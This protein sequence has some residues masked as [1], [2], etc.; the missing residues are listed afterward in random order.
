[1]Y[2]IFS[3]SRTDVYDYLRC[4]KIVAL[5][6][7]KNLKKPKPEKK[8]IP[9]RNFRY[10]IGTIGEVLT[11]KAFSTEDII[12][13]ISSDSITESYNEDQS[14]F[15]D[16][17]IEDF[18]DD[19]LESVIEKQSL[20]SIKVDL[21]KRGV[22][23]DVEMNN[24]L[25]NTVMG[26]GK[27]KGYINDEFGKIEILGHGESRNGVFPNK[28]RPDFVAMS[29][30]KKP[31]LVEV[32]NTSSK[33]KADQ[34][35][36]S[37]YNTIGS[38]YG[39]MCMEERIENNVKTIF[40]K[41]IDDAISQTLLIYPI[42]G[43]FEKITD[44]INIDKNIIKEIWLAKQLGLKGKSP[45]TDCHSKCPHHRLGELPED[46]FEP[47]I[48]LPLILSKGW[49]EQDIDLDTE[50]IRRY[51][52]KS[53][54]GRVIYDGLW[55]INFAENLAKDSLDK[56]KLEKKLEKLDKKRELFLDEVSVK[57][58][59]TKQELRKI[60]SSNFHSSIQKEQNKAEKLMK[61][62]LDVWKK[63]IGAKNLKSLRNTIKGQTTK[64]YP[65][66]KGTKKFVNDSWKLWK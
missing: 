25:K 51:L 7:W 10:E 64:L 27:I 18:T 2:G 43:K 31:I 11:Q 30:D 56:I 13:E 4:P 19:D 65:L 1:M 32:K 22:Q 5:K 6:T 55:D 60:T 52:Y 23:L 26:L 47:A 33:S 15:L 28:V 14:E 36:A 45:K 37:F 12:H 34:F 61:T 29:E 58:G 20:S 38:R 9:S 39:V 17:E 54:V 59:F 57:T 49:I 16:E 40:P 3:A 42:Q 24:I 46:N 53:T 35:Q 41:V 62:E 21:K 50:Y 44:M 48:P 66:P 8:E 63:I